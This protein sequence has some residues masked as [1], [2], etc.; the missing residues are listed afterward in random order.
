MINY[1]VNIWEGHRIVKKGEPEMSTSMI[2]YIIATES[3]DDKEE[4]FNKW[5]NEKHGPEGLAMGVYDTSY[6]Y[7]VVDFVEPPHQVPYV[8]LYDPSGDPLKARLA[9]NP[10]FIRN[11]WQK[12]PL[13]VDLLGVVWTG[14]FRQIYP[15]LNK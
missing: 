1:K 2:L 11:N 3:T 6:R 5:Y 13:W 12:D 4:K 7:K 8:T 9:W 10:D 15:P 14:G